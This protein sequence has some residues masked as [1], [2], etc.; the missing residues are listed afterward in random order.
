MTDHDSSTVHRLSLTDPTPTRPSAAAGLPS[1]L[2]ETNRPTGPATLADFETLGEP[3]DPDK[4]EHDADHMAESDPACPYCRSTYDPGTF[5]DMT[6]TFLAPLASGR[7]SPF[8]IDAESPG[9]RAAVITFLTAH[10]I[11]AR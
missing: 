11:D 1:S 4:A 8:T 7:L 2:D 3:I 5:H 6:V 10:G 9:R